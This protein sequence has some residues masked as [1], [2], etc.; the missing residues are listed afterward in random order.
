M[1][2]VWRP[3]VNTVLWYGSTFSVQN[4]SMVQWDRMFFMYYKYLQT[5]ITLEDFS[6][7]IIDMFFGIS[8]VSSLGAKYLNKP[9]DW[10]TDERQK[11]PSN[12]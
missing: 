9:L 10:F 1:D 3:N 7:C 4:S 6:I 2:F 5:T 11:L 8:T 12:I